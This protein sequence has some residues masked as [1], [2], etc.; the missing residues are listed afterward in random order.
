M[1]SEVGSG[2]IMTKCSRAPIPLDKN[3]KIVERVTKNHLM[4]TRKKFTSTITRTHVYKC[5]RTFQVKNS[6]MDKGLFPP[7]SF[8]LLS[9]G[10]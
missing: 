3:M 9:L 8:S 5:K 6:R 7:A 2:F 4:K 1:E 10:I